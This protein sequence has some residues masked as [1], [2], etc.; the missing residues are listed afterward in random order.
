MLVRIA[1]VLKRS[2]RGIIGMALAI[3]L[4]ASIAAP[5]LADTTTGNISGTVTTANGQGVP[6]VNVVAVAPAGRYTA[7]TDAKGFFSIVG[8]SPD[9]YSVTFSSSGYSGSIINGVT[10]N[11]TQTTTVNATVSAQLKSIGSR[12]AAPR[13]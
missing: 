8:V 3:A 7:K 5:A 1:H 2:L 12:R 10:V 9:T 11:P 4:A 13:V 6:N